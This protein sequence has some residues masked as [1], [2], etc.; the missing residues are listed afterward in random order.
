LL[1]F[2]YRQMPK[3]VS[4]GHVFVARPPLYKVSQKKH[5]RYVQTTDEMSRELMQRGLDGAKLTVDPA[6]PGAAPAA[7]YEGERLQRLIAVLDELEG[8]LQILERRGID[9]PKF[10]ARGLPLPIFRVLIAGDEHWFA[11]S[12]DADAFRKKEEE[13]LGQ[14]LVVADDPSR[15]SRPNG[16]S[17]GNGETGPVVT[18][19]KQELHEVKRIN[20]GLE[21]LRQFSL[22]TAEL[23][24]ALRVAGREPPP[25]FFLT[26]G[27]NKR[28]LRHLR[29]LA[30]E[31]R[32]FGEKGLTITRFKGL[33]EMDPEELWDTTL[34]PARRTLLKVHLEDAFKADEMF[35]TLMGEK[36]EPRRD[37][38]QKHALEVKDI[39]Y[40]GA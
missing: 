10:L 24:P 3:L 20:A 2:F 25:R 6:N 5:I 31:V 39:D 35:R 33:G 1:T 7:V 17:T 13:R 18:F 9:L 8:A 28:T 16:T 22:G 15:A 27:D 40:H 4:E 12:D 11:R 32:K 14:A 19:A 29:D 30:P 36:V 23:V 26:S 34:D 21:K 38:I 37:F